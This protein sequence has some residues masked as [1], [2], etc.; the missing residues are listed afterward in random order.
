MHKLVFL[1]LYFINIFFFFQEDKECKEANEGKI[2][3]KMK[4][5]RGKRRP[6]IVKDEVDDDAVVKKKRE[7]R[8]KIVEDDESYKNKII[9]LKK[10]NF[11]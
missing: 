8:Q 1:N 3:P 11:R 6:V 10:I 4:E 9:N 7:K 5:V 2:K